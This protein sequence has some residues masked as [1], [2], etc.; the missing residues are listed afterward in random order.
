[1]AENRPDRP[2]LLIVEDD[3]ELATLLGTLIEAEGY[4]VDLAHDAQR[5]LHLGLGHPYRVMVIDRRLPDMD[6]GL[7]AQLQRIEHRL[8]GPLF[9]RRP[10][11]VVPTDLGAHV[12]GRSREILDEFSDLLST[13]RVLSRSGLPPGAIGLGGWTTRGFR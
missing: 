1:M 7:T 4:R 3:A 6:G 5:G 11:G 13:A 2:G 10:D 9:H 8:G 12:L